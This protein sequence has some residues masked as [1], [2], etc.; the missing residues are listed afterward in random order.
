MVVILFG[1]RGKRL[2]YG[3]LDA[4]LIGYTDV[5]RPV[6]HNL[7]VY[8]ESSGEFRFWFFIS[9]SSFY[10]FSLCVCQTIFVVEK[11]VGWRMLIF[12]LCMNE[13]NIEAIFL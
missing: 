11:T 9:V 5:G 3:P 10:R 7:Y 2:G 4:A 1:G 12:F 6:Y 8:M 13:W